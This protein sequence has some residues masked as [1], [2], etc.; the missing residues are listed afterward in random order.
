MNDTL[1]RDEVIEAQRQWAP[2]SSQQTLGLLALYD[3]SDWSS[4]PMSPSIHCRRSRRSVVL[5]GRRRQLSGR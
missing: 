1:T 2:A 3:F 4:S 5:Y